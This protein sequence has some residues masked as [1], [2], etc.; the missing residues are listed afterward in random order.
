MA[1]KRWNVIVDD[2]EANDWRKLQK[3][4]CRFNEIHV[5]D[6]AYKKDVEHFSSPPNN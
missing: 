1:D 5:I 6:V 3:R 2:V 4:S